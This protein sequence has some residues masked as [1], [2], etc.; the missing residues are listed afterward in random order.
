MYCI[1]HGNFENIL[2]LGTLSVE[3]IGPFSH[4]AAAESFAENNLT[5][6]WMIDRMADQSHIAM[7]N[8]KV[9]SMEANN[10]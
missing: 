5:E 1:L 8:E 4:Y 7:S 3:I 6:D 2:A 9:P 10:V